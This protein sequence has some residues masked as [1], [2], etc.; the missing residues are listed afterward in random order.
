MMKKPIVVL[1]FSCFFFLSANSQN[2]NPEEI[3]R[4]F[5]QEKLSEYK[6]FRSEINKKYSEFMRQKW[7]WFKSE[8]SIEDIDKDVKPM[9]VPEAPDEQDL[10][11]QKKGILLHKKV[12]NIDNGPKVKQPNPLAP[13]KE[14]PQ[15]ESY[16]TFSVYGTNMK[17]RFKEMSKYT[18]Q[19]S[20][21]GSVADMWNYLSDESFNN[22]I[23]D[24]LTLR[25]KHNLC[26]WAYLNMLKE[27]CN[28]YYGTASNESV[29]MQTFLFNQSGYKTRIGRS[30]SNKLYIMV[31]SPNTIYGKSY[32]KIDNEMFYPIDFSEN[33][34]YIFT[35]KY[36]GEKMMSLDINKEQNFDLALSEKHIIKSKTKD[37]LS[38]NLSFNSN[39]LNFY[40]SYPQSH[41]NNNEMT[42]WL[43]YA[44]TPI[45]KEVKEQLYPVLKDKI[46]DKNEVEAAN[47]LI[48]FVQTAFEYQTD[49]KV[50][51]QDHPFF[52][53][54]TLFYPYSDCEDRAMLYSRLI[55]D[56]LGLDTVLLYYPGH[57]AMAVKFNQTIEGKTLII[58][59]EEYTYCEP[60]CNNYVPVGWCPP[61][62]E[63]IKPTVIKY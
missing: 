40:L 19:G 45:S 25:I 36:P 50:W 37:S 44:S 2:S 21:E 63:S 49:E 6:E 7:T 41:K 23:R 1:T 58:N 60:T 61:K 62:L 26:D 22:L 39:L 35:Q 28:Q 12:V 38:V 9:P 51:G 14:V 30:N 15:A 16:F 27:L 46:K 33:G 13:I 31:A 10:K 42:K 52:P 11:N 53:E 57:L 17:V 59:D 24:C 48:G 56:L 29:V 54:E 32:F 18:L 3:Y 5:R 34:L 43:V 47:I 8:E 4:Q 20:D 55:R